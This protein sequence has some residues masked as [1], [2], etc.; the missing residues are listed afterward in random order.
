MKKINVHGG[1]NRHVPGIISYLDEVTEDRKIKNKVIEL[2]RDE[3]NKVYDC[4]E[5]TARTQRGN[6]YG[7]VKK[8]NAHAVDLDVSIHINGCKKSKKDRKTKGVEVLIQNSN[9]KAKAAAERICKKVAELG[10]TNRGVE[11]RKDLY[12]LNRTKAPALLVE[13][14]FAD[15]EDDAIK[16]KK[17][18]VNA[19]A[20]AIAEGI[21]NK[22]I[23]EKK[24]NTGS[25][26]S[27]E[28]VTKAFKVRTNRK[29]VIYSRPGGKKVGKADVSVYTIIATK[30]RNNMPYGKLKSGQGWIKIHS[31]YCTRV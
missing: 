9:S 24:E 22:T 2:L 6:L 28:K 25:P 31:K 18:G 26:E 4:T 29:L 27:A 21:L 3:G 19:M 12:V 5:N 1:H 17:T 7:I 8:C 16:Y 14:C 10:F 30:Y 20:K 11:V 13:C 15:D 23:Q